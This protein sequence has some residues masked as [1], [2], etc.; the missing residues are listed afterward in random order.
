MTIAISVQKKLIF[1]VH[2]SYSIIS[3]KKMLNYAD[4]DVIIA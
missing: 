1:K 2:T 4:Y 3:D